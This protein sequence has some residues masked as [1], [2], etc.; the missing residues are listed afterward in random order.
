MAS[1]MMWGP[2]VEVE[3]PALGVSSSP[4]E[5]GAF[6]APSAAAPPLRVSPGVFF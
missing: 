6:A 4:S 3:D 5:E 2:G 1:N